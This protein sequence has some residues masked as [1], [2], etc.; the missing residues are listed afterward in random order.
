ME[1][2]NNNETFQRFESWRCW[3]ILSE[4]GPKDEG[5]VDRALRSAYFEDLDE[6]GKAYELESRKPLVTINQAFQVGIA[7]YQLA[8]LRILEF[9]HHFLDRFVARQDFELIQMDT[10]N[11]YL[12][13][14][15]ESLEEV[16]KPEMREVFE[17]EKKQ[18]LSWNKRSGRTPWLFKPEFEGRRMIALCSKCYFAEADEKAK[19]RTKTRGAGSKRR[20]TRAKT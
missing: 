3:T 2:G 1:I 16:V 18:W 15:G 7:V 8:K 4:K 12:A 10:D 17:A 14:A 20:S 6:I 19:R 9:Y 5:V 11:N 13:I